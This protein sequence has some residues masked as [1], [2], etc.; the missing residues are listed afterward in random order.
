[1]AL[2]SDLEDWCYDVF[3]SVWTTRNGTKVPDEDSKLGLKNE[4]IEIEGTVLYADMADST[5]LV[6]TKTKHRSAE[7]Y[8]TFLY[9]AAK[10]IREYEGV[11][12]AYDGDRVMAVFIGGSKNTNAVRAALRIKWAVKNI[13]IPQMKKVYTDDDYEIKH[14]TG[15]DTSKLF[16]AKTGV[17]G[18]ND[19]VWVGRAANHAAKLSALP[20][21]YTYITKDVYDGMNEEVKVY[22][23]REM[24]EER[25][26]NFNDSTIYRSSWGWA[27]D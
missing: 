14:V 12:T 8:K 20:P 5:A 18:A 15:V 11:I 3:K 1:M 10:I 19:L 23:G 27:I 16:V 4:A 26:W 2:K 24:W 22:K 21:T 6:D 17:R 9:C 7:I 25:K 13:V